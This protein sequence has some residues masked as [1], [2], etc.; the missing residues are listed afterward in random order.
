MYLPASPKAPTTALGN[1]EDPSY[2]PGRSD[3][4]RYNEPKMEQGKD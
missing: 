2:L 1:S 4:C 3:E